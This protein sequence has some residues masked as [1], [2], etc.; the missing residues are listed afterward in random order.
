[1]KVF[2]VRIVPHF[3]DYRV[4]FVAHP[5]DCTELLWGVRPSVQIVRALPEG[6]RFLE[7]DPSFRIR[8]KMRALFAVKLEPYPMV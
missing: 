3:E 2:A 4:Q 6:L 8:P 1:M 5:S 7:A